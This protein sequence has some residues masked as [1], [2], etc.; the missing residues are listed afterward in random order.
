MNPLD[1]ITKKTTTALV[2][3]NPAGMC[4]EAVRGLAASMSRSTSLLKAMA[5][6]LARPRHATI[7]SNW[8]HEKP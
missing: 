8:I 3:N 6:A 1:V 2:A 4:L 5:A 7:P